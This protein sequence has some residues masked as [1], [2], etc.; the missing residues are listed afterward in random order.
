M[1]KFR[2]PWIPIIGAVIVFFFYWIDIDDLTETVTTQPCSERPQTTCQDYTDDSDTISPEIIGVSPQNNE[3]NVDPSSNAVFRI[4]DHDSGVNIGSLQAYIDMPSISFDVYNLTDIDVIS[5]EAVNEDCYETEVAL[6]EDIPDGN[7]IIWGVSICDCAENLSEGS[8]RAVNETLVTYYLWEMMYVVQFI[9]WWFA[10][11]GPQLIERSWGVV[12]DSRTKQ[13]L[14]R[15]VVRLYSKGNEL[16]ESVVTDANGVFVLKPNAGTYTLIASLSKYTFPSSLQPQKTD[17]RR[18]NLYYGEKITVAE[19]GK[20]LKICIPLDPSD[21]AAKLSTTQR[22]SSSAMGT[23]TSMNTV[24]LALTGVL[25]PVIWLEPPWIIHTLIYAGVNIL[26]LILQFIL[27][28]KAQ[29]RFGVVRDERRKPAEGVELGLYDINY[30]QLIDKKVTDKKG[31]YQ[32]V[33]PGKKY[34]IKPTGAGFVLIGYE[35]EKGLPVGRKTD[36]DILIAPDFQVR[37]T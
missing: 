28:K 5:Y 18:K 33:V 17:G 13:P 22:I 9:I 24:I 14:S 37:R 12:Y 34:Y 36:D 8:I 23:L 19:D 3:Y 32:F 30:D 4:C 31:R 10:I 1:R 7:S 11:F 35:K 20:P 6:G 25:M 29:G 27:K 2:V 16:V 26:L 15:A 21:S